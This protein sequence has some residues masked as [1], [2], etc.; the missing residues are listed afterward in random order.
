LCFCSM[1]ML[2]SVAQRGQRQWHLNWLKNH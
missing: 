2:R 1:M